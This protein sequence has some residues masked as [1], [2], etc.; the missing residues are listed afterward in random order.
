MRQKNL[1]DTSGTKTKSN[2]L[3]YGKC[4]VSKDD[5]HKEV[6]ASDENEKNCH[7]RLSD[8]VEAIISSSY[9]RFQRLSNPCE[10]LTYIQKPQISV[11]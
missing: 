3:R 7:C 11:D 1:S 6:E 5:G 10:D 8:K 9:I 4:E 2:F